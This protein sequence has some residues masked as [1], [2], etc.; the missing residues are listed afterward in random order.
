MAESAGQGGSYGH[1]AHEDRQGERLGISRMAQKQLEI[2]RPER[3]VYQ[4]GKARDEEYQ[5]QRVSSR[6]VARRA[7]FGKFGA[8]AVGH[9][10][11]SRGI[12]WLAGVPLGHEGADLRFD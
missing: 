7:G 12:I 8:Q 5:D 3:F 11:F 2:M 10:R 6:S 1:A 9:G 4:P